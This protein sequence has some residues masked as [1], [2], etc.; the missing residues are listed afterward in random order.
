MD[1]NFDDRE[2]HITY[3]DFI[4]NDKDEKKRKRAEKKRRRHYK[5][6]DRKQSKRGIASTV[7]AAVALAFII[8]AVVISARAG[9]EGGEMVGEL[10]FLSL[11]VSLAAVATGL[12][13]FRQTDV[14]YRFAWTGIITGGIVW[15]FD[16]VVIVIGM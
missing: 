5:F 10:G 1:I 8:A 14:F 16:A 3:E 7:L 11:L 4:R 12:L 6:S 15:I 9:G 13:A 2:Q